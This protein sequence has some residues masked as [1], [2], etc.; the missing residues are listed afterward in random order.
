VENGLVCVAGLYQRCEVTSG[1]RSF[2][3]GLLKL[4]QSDGNL[5]IIPGTTKSVRWVQAVVEVGAGWHSVS[6][7]I[8]PKPFLS[9]LT[10]AESPRDLVSSFETIL[11]F[12]FCRYGTNSGIVILHDL[13]RDALQ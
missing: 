13:R 11:L 9:L 10:L 7:R 5:G 6:F 8:A 4:R 1:R 3:R 2:R 12:F